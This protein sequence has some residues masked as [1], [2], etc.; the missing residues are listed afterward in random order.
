MIQISVRRHL[1]SYLTLLY[2]IIFD[3][4]AN[5]IASQIITDEIF[6]FD[7]KNYLTVPS[8]PVS[9]A[10]RLITNYITHRITKDQ[11]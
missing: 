3:L 11:R 1:Q 5:D 6:E 7:R 8:Q 2:Y 4:L 10:V 9:F